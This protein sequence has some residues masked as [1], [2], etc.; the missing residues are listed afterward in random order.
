MVSGRSHRSPPDH[1]PGSPTG[2]ARAALR[3]LAD[4]RR[5]FGVRDP[6]HR[7]HAEARCPL[8]WNRRRRRTYTPGTQPTPC[9]PRRRRGPGLRDQPRPGRPAPPATGLAWVCRAC[10][11]THLTA[12]CGLCT[13][14]RKPL[15]TAPSP[16]ETD[17][18]YY[19]WKAAND[20]GRFRLNC[21]ELTGQTDSLDRQSRQSRFL[22]VTPNRSA[23]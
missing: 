10:R 6:P 15:P 21:A 18:D 7:T 20:A 5:F 19:A 3:V 22:P 12:G 16:A 1:T 8:D 11:R 23:R 13:K 2:Y 9:Q 14:C 4:Q 17:T